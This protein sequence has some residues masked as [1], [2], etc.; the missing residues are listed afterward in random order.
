L[1]YDTLGFI[2][3][4]TS[5]ANWGSWKVPEIP[6][7]PEYAYYVLPPWLI[8]EEEVMTM[9]K[10]QVKRIIDTSYSW[11]GLNNIYNGMRFIT[12]YMEVVKESQGYSQLWADMAG[13]MDW[14]SVQLNHFVI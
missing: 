4:S 6:I 3:N 9:S 1:R 2:S 5:I 10:S 11:Y 12:D 13:M 14:S 8:D 7:E